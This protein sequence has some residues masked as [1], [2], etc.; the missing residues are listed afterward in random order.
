VLKRIEQVDVHEPDSTP[1]FPVRIV[2]CG[3]LTDRKHQDSVT[4]ENDK[5]RAAKSKLMKDISSDEESN[6]GQHKGRHKKSSKRKRKKRRYSYSESDSSSESETESSDSESDSDTYSSD[7]SDVS[8]SSDDRR[9]RRKRQSKKNKRKRSRRKRDHR[10][11]RRRR[12][13]DR[14][15]KQKSKRLIESWSNTRSQNLPERDCF[16]ISDAALA[17]FFKTIPTA[18]NPMSSVN[19][20]RKPDPRQGAKK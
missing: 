20:G 3:E 19:T 9:R 8:S 11:E 7:S 1:V 18:P 14:K 6:E 2:D 10:R 16:R 12:K 13:R 15:A 4:T 5:K 17:E